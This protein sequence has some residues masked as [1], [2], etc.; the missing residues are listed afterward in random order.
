MCGVI[1]VKVA[2]AVVKMDDRN[3]NIDCAT[4]TVYF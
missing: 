3:Y 1:V 4:V 2:V